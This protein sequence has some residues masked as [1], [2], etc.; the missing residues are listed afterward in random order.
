[1][2]I[3]N[4][5]ADEILDEETLP[6]RY[7]AYSP[8]FRAEAGSAGKDTRGLVRQHQFDKVEMVRFCALEQADQELD[9][10]VDRASALMTALELPHRVVLKCVGDTGFSAE[11][12]YDLEVWLPAQ[13]RY[14]EIS[15]CSTCG[16]FQARR[17]KIR[18]K[19]GKD[20]PKPVATLNGSGLA[21]GRTWLALL[22]NH[23]QED[24]SVHVPPALRPYLR[25]LDVLR[26]K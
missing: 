26:S 5:H 22:E 7:C 9:L 10:M 21:I 20:K 23:Q 6:L 11:K 2:P 3:T 8:C 19:K 24:G 18:S 14:R 16:P 1:V 13:D 15:S 12:S 17:A 4:F 25:G